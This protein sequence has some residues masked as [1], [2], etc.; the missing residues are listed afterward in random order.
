M[1]TTEPLSLEQLAVATQAFLAAMA[2][3]FYTR[4]PDAV[5]CR[6]PAWESLNK[7]DRAMLM[8]SLRAGYGAA[9]DEKA[10]ERFRDLAKTG[11]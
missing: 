10:I 4:H 6:V 2:R 5:E 9:F 3:E 8:R 11:A 1:A 7:A